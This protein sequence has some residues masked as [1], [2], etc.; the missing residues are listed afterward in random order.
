FVSLPDPTSIEGT[1]RFARATFVR[2]IERRLEAQGRLGDLT[3]LM[4]GGPYPAPNDLAERLGEHLL[5]SEVRAQ[6]ERFEFRFVM[7]ETRARSDLD[8]GA[9][10]VSAAWRRL[11]VRLSYLGY[12]DYDDAAWN[13]LRIGRPLLIESP[14]TKASRNIEK[15]ARTLLALD[16]GKRRE[17]PRIQVPAH[18]HH[19]L[20]EVDRGATEEEVRRAYKR[21]RE[22]YSSGSLAV[23]G[24]FD[25]D[26]LKALRARIDEA[27][28]VLLD[29]SRRRPYE[30]SVFPEG[31]APRIEP[32][33]PEPGPA[34]PAPTILPETQFNGALLRAV[35]QAQGLTLQDVG[36]RTKIGLEYLKAI[37]EDAFDRLPALVYVQGFVREFAKCLELDAQHVSRTYMRAY[38][39]ARPEGP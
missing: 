27:H 34:P 11:G 35:R 33:P 31:S 15:V 26:A 13:S 9:D 21:F 38:R 24:L 23:C 39:R 37:E 7:N 6:M 20:L 32:S 18:S 5:A 1:F 2:Q 10:M 17:A 4:T 36:G 19:D 8:L 3:L 12:I 28:D 14:G 22:V 29:P 30:L 25:A 16:A